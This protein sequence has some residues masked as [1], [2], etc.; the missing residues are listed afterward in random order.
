MRIST[1]LIKFNFHPILI[2][3]FLM[4]F[5]V[6]CSKK[7]AVD[8]IVTHE[9]GEIPGLGNTLGELTGS[10]FVLPGGLTLEGEI[11][12][13]DGYYYGQGPAISN[14]KLE[15]PQAK[16][17]AKELSTREV[18]FANLKAV[19][20]VSEVGSGRYVRLLIHVR[21]NT[22]SKKTL[23]FP[24]GLIIKSR[25]GDYQNGILLKKTSVEIPANDVHAVV[26]YMYCGNESRSASS[27][28]EQY[29]WAVVSNSSLIVDLCNRLADKKINYEEFEYNDLGTYN[30]QRSKLQSILWKLTDNYAPLSD[31]D[32]DWINGLPGSR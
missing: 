14:D 16:K 4:V 28:Y 23:N 3:L 12:G 27:S 9:P 5:V 32:I 7:D 6:S 2:F 22:G 25:S 18:S 19:S 20:G 24:A 31:E 15:L 1:K 11:T 10:P 26:L 17:H 8:P 13:Y 21:N 29:D 30:T